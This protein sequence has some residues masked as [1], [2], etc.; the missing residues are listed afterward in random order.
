MIVG[1]IYVTAGAILIGVPTGIFCAVFMAKF[2]PEKLYRI[3]K[4]SIELMAGIPSIVYGFFGLMVIVP[5]MQNLFGDHAVNIAEWV[6]YSVTGVHR[7]EN[8]SL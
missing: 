6:E 2:C 3:L 7:K 4:P 1:S 5:A 8:V